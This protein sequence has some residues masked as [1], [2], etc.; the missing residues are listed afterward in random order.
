MRAMSQR[1]PGAPLSLERLP[2]PRPGPGQVLLKVE[3]CAVCRTDLHVVDGEL[4]GLR[5]PVTPGHEVIG[6]VE[7]TGE[8]VDPRLA[9]RRA[10][11]AWLAWTCGRCAFCLTGR[12][13]LCDAAAFTGY[14]RDGGFASHMLAETAYVYPL[15]QA[16]PAESMAPWMC[17]GLIGWRALRAAG[18]ARRLGV[19]GFGSA[20]QALAQIC[21]WQHRRLHAYTRPGDAVAQLHARTLGAAWAGDSGVDPPEP[22]DAAIIFAPVG[23]LVP[24]ALRA[25]RKGGCVVCGGIHMTDIPAFP[26]RLLWGERKLVSVA[27]LTRADAREFLALA[28]AAGI[29]CDVRTYPLEQANDALDD[30]RQG[31]LQATAVLIP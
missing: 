1:A 3:A 15:P 11:A 31:R 2:T 14:T 22:L 29:H 21:A 20:G 23:E 12:E 27:N 16:G 25:V 18:D 6:I 28:P 5:Y 26:Y 24:M 30:L 8:G 17:A 13:N 4:P 19:Y 9:G 7:E 10:G